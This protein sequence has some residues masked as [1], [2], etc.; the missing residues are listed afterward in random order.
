MIFVG[1][2]CLALFIPA[3][4]TFKSLPVEPD[5]G[6]GP[7]EQYFDFNDGVSDTCRDFFQSEKDNEIIEIIDNLN[8]KTQTSDG[9]TVECTYSCYFEI[10][11]KKT[12][13][14]PVLSLQEIIG[15]VYDIEPYKKIYKDRMEIVNSYYDEF[16]YLYKTPEDIPETDRYDGYKDDFRQ[17]VIIEFKN[18]T[19]Y[20][21]KYVFANLRGS[22]II[23]NI[24]LVFTNNEGEEK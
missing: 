13:N 22:Q 24:D 19:K 18:A 2:F 5:P 17:I 21:I 15:R 8:E 16:F 1:I 6:Y 10:T 14:Y 9:E 11:L 7:N 12:E 4:C 23:K 20:K 3:G